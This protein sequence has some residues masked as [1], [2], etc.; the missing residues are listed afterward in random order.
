MGWGKSIAKETR[1]IPKKSANSGN[2]NNK[3]LIN[4]D[5]I[6]DLSK[7]Q[8]R[9]DSIALLQQEIQSIKPKFEASKSDQPPSKKSGKVNGKKKKVRDPKKRY[10]RTFQR[11]YY[12]RDGD[13]SSHSSLQSDWQT[14]NSSE[15]EKPQSIYISS[16]AAEVANEPKEHSKDNSKDDMTPFDN[17]NDKKSD[18]SNREIKTGKPDSDKKSDSEDEKEQDDT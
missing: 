5:N 4:N 18:K 2:S 14:I 9:S 8:H 13:Q 11:I 16:K 12:E 1:R 17:I 10:K 7:I 15:H 3:N 6:N